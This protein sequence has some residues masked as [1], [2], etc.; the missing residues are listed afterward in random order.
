MRKSITILAATLTAV[1][2][3]SLLTA[4]SKSSVL[5]FLP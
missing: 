2:A 1:L 3:T 5:A 4:T